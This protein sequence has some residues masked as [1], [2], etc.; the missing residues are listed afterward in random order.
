VSDPETP[1]LPQTTHF[2]ALHR[3]IIGFV[4]SLIQR[5]DTLVPERFICIFVLPAQVFVS[6]LKHPRQKVS[7][8]H[9]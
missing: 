8:Q 4:K 6:V 5:P 2:S 7:G 1:S 3:L 9:P